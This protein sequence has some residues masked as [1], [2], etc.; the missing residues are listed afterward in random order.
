M[1]DDA[2][3]GRPKNDQVSP[4]PPAQT[5]ELTIT[6]VTSYLI[7]TSRKTL[8]TV[9]TLEELGP[10]YRKVLTHNLLAGWW[11]FPFGIVWT[12]MHLAGNRK[13][14]AHLRELAAGGRAEAGWWPDPTG[15]S[16]QRY[17]D[18]QAWTDK[19]A[20]VGVDPIGPP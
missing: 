18:G 4:P 8:T 11:G 16:A 15:R 17:W 10:F 6:Q 1:T 20:D 9:G 5:F 13:A 14:M 12:I 7:F 19:V 2:L 3:V